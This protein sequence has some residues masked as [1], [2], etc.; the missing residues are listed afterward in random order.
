MAITA[1][2]RA[3]RKGRVWASEVPCILGVSPWK[4][5]WDVWAEKR[6]LLEDKDEP[7]A[8]HLTIG[9]LMEEPLLQYA[10]ITMGLGAIVR[11]PER[12]HPKLPLGAHM[13]ALVQSDG[14]NLEAKNIHYANPHFDR[15]GE[16]GTDA[17]PDDV[18]IQVHA[19]MMCLDHLK[20]DASYSHV[21]ANVAGDFMMYRV[22]RSDEI[23]E[24][25]ANEISEFWEKNVL[26]GVEPDASPT[27]SVAKC[28]RQEIGKRLPLDVEVAKAFI[29]A[30]DAR[31]AAAKT[32]NETKAR[33]LA[34]MGD[35]QFGDAGPLGTFE[36]RL[37]QRD[38]YDVKPSSHKRLFHTKKKK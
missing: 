5:K 14:S 33:L 28:L 34:S 30:G 15:W 4:S 27:L 23:S 20:A 12:K 10:S 35:A 7:E 36:N 16:E 37:M 25:I 24:I 31:K 17:V 8:K 21:V 19:Q 38:G 29:E 13:D 22:D 2:Q 32:E 6:G 18:I 3:D 9:Q 11:N 1:S 26:G